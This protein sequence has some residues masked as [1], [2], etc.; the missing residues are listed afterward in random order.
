MCF[1]NF[2]ILKIRTLLLCVYNNIVLSPDV[3]GPPDVSI[4][5]KS[6]Q[7]LIDDV[8]LTVNWTQE[9]GQYPFH[10]DINTLP[11]QG[12][13]IRFIDDT[14]IELTVP[15]NVSFNIS[16]TTNLCNRTLATTTH[17]L[18]VYTR[19]P[20]FCHVPVLQPNVQATLNYS[21][22]LV[23][24]SILSFVCSSG[25]TFSGPNTTTCL[26]NG[27]WTLNPNLV[28]CKGL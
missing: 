2:F 13:I 22:P 4:Q 10:Y 26:S 14:S 9:N 18:P 20:S 11:H 24:G 21:Q 25:L 7:F 19:A 6:E 12:A 28:E 16:I 3:S 27:Q 8:T 1:I 5:E 15:Y 17:S 23:E